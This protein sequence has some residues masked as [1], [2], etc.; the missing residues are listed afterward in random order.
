MSSLIMSMVETKVNS[1][2]FSILKGT[3]SRCL[4]SF[5]KYGKVREIYFSFDQKAMFGA[6][7]TAIKKLS[8]KIIVSTNTSREVIRIYWF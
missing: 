4:N 1:K 3:F 8:L 7:I 5:I 6:I 2:Y